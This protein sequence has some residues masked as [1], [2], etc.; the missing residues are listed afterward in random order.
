MAPK[1]SRTSDDPVAVEHRRGE[2]RAHA[3]RDQR[4]GDEDRDPQQVAREEERQPRERRAP[5]S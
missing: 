1:R 5:T 4:R 2:Q 3:E